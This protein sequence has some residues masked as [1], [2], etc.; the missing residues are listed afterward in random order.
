MNSQPDPNFKPN[1]VDQMIKSFSQPLEPEK[2]QELMAKLEQ[3]REKFLADKE[4]EKMPDL[5]HSR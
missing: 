3:E 4:Q 1:D 5:G 2:K